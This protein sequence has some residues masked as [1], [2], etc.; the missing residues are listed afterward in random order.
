MKKIVRKLM[1]LLD[2]RQKRIMILLI[3]LMLVGAVLETAGVSM[4][5]PAMQVVMDA[6]AV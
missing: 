3:L 1:V 6:H 4:V 5:V 2:K